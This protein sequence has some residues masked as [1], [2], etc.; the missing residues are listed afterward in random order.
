MNA[1]PLAQADPVPPGWTAEN[2]EV[3]GYTSMDGRPGFKIS[4]T[5]AGDRWHAIT[6]HYHVPWLERG[7]CHRS[8]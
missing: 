5:R 8:A 4:M 6:A 7:R 1:L 3:L 2:M